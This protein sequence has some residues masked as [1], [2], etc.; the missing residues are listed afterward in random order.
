MYPRALRVR[1]Y[2]GVDLMRVW[3]PCDAKGWRK[4]E[5]DI[6]GFESKRTGRNVDLDSSKEHTW[7]ASVQAALIEERWALTSLGTHNVELLPFEPGIVS[8]LLCKSDNTEMAVPMSSNHLGAVSILEL[9]CQ[10]LASS[11]LWPCR[12]SQRLTLFSAKSFRQQSIKPTA[13]L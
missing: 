1:L 4:T 13:S 6:G 9:L 8:E 2:D 10:L 12:C 11:F 7:A 5:I 3:R